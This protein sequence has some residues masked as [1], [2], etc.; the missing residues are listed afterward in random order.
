MLSSRF[1]P[2]ALVLAGLLSFAVGCGKPDPVK[3]EPVAENTSPP[4]PVDPPPKPPA[5]PLPPITIPGIPLPPDEGHRPMTPPAPLPPDEPVVPGPMV[6]LPPAIPN[7]PNPAPPVG[8]EPVNVPPADPNEK[9]K[10][11]KLIAGRDLSEWVKEALAHKDPQF[12]EAAIRVLPLFGPDAR[13]PII[14][15]LCEVIRNK[16][17][18]PSIRVAA[19][20]IVTNLGFDFRIDDTKATPEEKKKM[21]ELRAASREVIGALMNVMADT[22]PGSPLRL[23]CVQSLATFGAD[24]HK[25]VGSLTNPS[26]GTL[27]MMATDFSWAT[28]HAVAQTLGAVG[29]PPEKDGKP[30]WTGNPYEPATDILLNILLKDRCA[31]VR[32]AAVQSLLMLGPPKVKDLAEYAKAIDKFLKPVVLRVEPAVPGGKV[33]EDDHAVLVWLWLLQLSYD[34]RKLADNVKKIAHEVKEPK[35]PGVRLQALYALTALGPRSAPAMSE[36][37]YALEHYED[38]AILAAAMTAVAAVG[39]KGGA[40]ALPELTALKDGKRDEKKP[41]KAPKDWKPDPTL[42]LFAA[43]TID[44]VTGKKKL[45]EV[46]EEKDKEKEEMKK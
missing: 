7:P 16:D 23:Y 45:I 17:S 44:V 10:F 30:D 28:R 15:P 5:D 6:V 18:D 37:R 9:P 27:R 35:E 26:P 19:I 22:L 32:V 2:S 25:A 8:P 13:K 46:K 43:D 1:A 4:F 29:V 39:T 12:R 31:A 20:S 36:L 3:S 40:D 14:G 11:P 38:P 24:A 21:A 34:D 41:E 42:R 33:L